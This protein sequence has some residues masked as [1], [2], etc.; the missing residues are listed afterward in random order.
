MNPS[1][2]R[3][4]LN[5][6]DKIKYHEVKILGVCRGHQLIN[7]YFGGNLCQ[8][9]F[10]SGMESHEIMHEIFW[11]YSGYFSKKFNI[12]N[13]LHHQGVTSSGY[14]F[15]VAALK[16]SII[17]ATIYKDKYFTVQWHPEFMEENHQNIFRKV[18]KSWV[19]GEN[20]ISDFLIRDDLKEKNK[21]SDFSFDKGLFTNTINTTDVY[22]EEEEDE[23][24]EPDFI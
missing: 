19:E 22:Y 17:E 3:I 2:D 1:R 9:I 13:S 11:K 8:D 20:K 12:V 15:I 14:S 24:D 21:D 16:K 5:L 10:L 6:L 4:E 7:A 23:E 18:I